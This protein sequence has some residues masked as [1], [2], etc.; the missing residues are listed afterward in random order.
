MVRA[1]PSLYGLVERLRLLPEKIQGPW[2]L[3]SDFRS[4]YRHTLGLQEDLVAAA[5]RHQKQLHHGF[6]R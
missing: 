4:R 2:G 5:S 1:R 6:A 3:E